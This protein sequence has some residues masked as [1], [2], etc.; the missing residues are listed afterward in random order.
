LYSLLSADTNSSIVRQQDSFL[1]IISN[2]IILGLFIDPTVVESKNLVWIGYSID[3]FILSLL[4][5]FFMRI[6]KKFYSS[7]I[8]IDE[9]IYYKSKE[10]DIYTDTSFYKKLFKWISKRFL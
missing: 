5:Y 2:S 4:I 7:N 1:N 8:M 3:I 6:Y 9:H 10:D